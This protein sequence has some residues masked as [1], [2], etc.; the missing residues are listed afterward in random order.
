MEGYDRFTYKA[1]AAD[2]E[3][4][5]GEDLQEAAANVKENAEGPDQWGPGDLKKL[6]PLAYSRLAQMLNAIEKGAERPAQM[7]K[8]R[9][10][11]MCK[12]E[13]VALN[14]LAYRVL[15]MLP[16]IYRL[17]GRTR[18]AHLQPWVAEWATPDMY[19][20][21]EGQGAEEAAY[22][23]ALLIEHCRLTGQEFTGGAADIYIF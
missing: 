17:W 3:P 10:A 2:L 4:L 6:F 23:T 13:E 21:T 16:A 12:A 7:N 18:L 1:P 15:L 19:A 22:R 14:P 8:S 5:T 20:G 9:A 11:F